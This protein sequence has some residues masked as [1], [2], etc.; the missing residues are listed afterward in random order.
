M[1]EAPRIF[2]IAALTLQDEDGFKTGDTFAFG[3]T[4]NSKAWATKEAGF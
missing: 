1:P 2:D 4:I 3:S